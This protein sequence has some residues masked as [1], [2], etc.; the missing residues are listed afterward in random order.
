MAQ[1]FFKMISKLIMDILRM[2]KN[3]ESDVLSVTEKDIKEIFEMIAQMV[4]VHSQI[5]I[6]TYM[7]DS[8]NKIQQKDGEYLFRIMKNILDNGKILKDREMATINFQIMS[9]I[10]ENGIR[11]NAMGQGSLFFKMEID[12]LENGRMIKGTDQV[13]FIQLME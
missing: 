10:W 13:F 1:V 2:T 3:M 6:I 8:G 4:L 11:I 5:V 12:L 7:K 9:F